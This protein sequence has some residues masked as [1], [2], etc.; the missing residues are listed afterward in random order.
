MIVM[1]GIFYCDSLEAQK[2]NRKERQSGFVPLNT[3]DLCC[4]HWALPYNHVFILYCNLDINALIVSVRL[5]SLP[6][7]G[8]EKT[9]R[10]TEKSLFPSSSSSSPSSSFFASARPH[11]FHLSYPSF[12]SSI[13]NHPYYFYSYSYSY[14]HI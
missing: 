6:R 12:L 10:A 11:S 14:T 4:H 5:A 8:Q 2:R 13:P 1:R 7:E 9:K 3:K